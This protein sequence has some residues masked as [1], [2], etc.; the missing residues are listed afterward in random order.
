MKKIYYLML[1]LVAAVSFTSC[2]DDTDNPYE[3]TSQL[4]VLRSSVLFDSKGGTGFV[5][6]EA[7][8]AITATLN[9]S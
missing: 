8:S 1:L 6:F 7:P 9:S 5:K 3:R 4:K 2:N